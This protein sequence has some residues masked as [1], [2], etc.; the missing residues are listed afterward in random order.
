MVRPAIT[1]RLASGSQL[2]QKALEVL[3]QDCLKKKSQTAKNLSMTRAMKRPCLE[4]D[5]NDGD[6][7][8]SDA[9]QEVGNPVAIWLADPAIAAPRD[10]NNDCTWDVRARRKLSVIHV[11][12]LDGI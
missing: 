7:D 3:L 10:A 5:D 4:D 11:R 1:A 6:D 9:V 12:T 8:E 2:Q